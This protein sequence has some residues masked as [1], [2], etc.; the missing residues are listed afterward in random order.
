MGGH[1]AAHLIAENQLWSLPVHPTQLYSTIDGLVLMT[2]LL[3]YYPL[4]NRDGQV[5]ALLMVTYP[6]TRFLIEHLR[7][8]EHVFFA[9]MTVSQNISVA[10]ILCGAAFWFWLSRQPRGLYA[11]LE[12]P[13]DLPGVPA[14][15]H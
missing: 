9:G 10:L 1:Q 2:L 3:A 5:M 11:D 4:R 15:A 13:V 14:A 12:G 6:V 8:D 7:S